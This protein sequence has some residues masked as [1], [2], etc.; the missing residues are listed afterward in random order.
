MFYGDTE[1]LFYGDSEDPEV[2]PPSQPR[3]KRP[4]PV[5]LRACVQSEYD[6]AI[7]DPT[8]YMCEF[9]YQNRYQYLNLWPY[10]VFSMSMMLWWDVNQII[11][12]ELVYN[13]IF[14]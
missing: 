2:K 9:D 3:Y 11:C 6:T 8:K 1:V 12:Q 4:I 5:K 13:V 10:I 14:P 7:K